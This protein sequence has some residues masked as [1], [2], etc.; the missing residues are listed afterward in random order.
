MCRMCEDPNSTRADLR[1]WTVATIAERGWCL[2]YVEPEDYEESLVYTVGLTG[3]KKPELVVEGLGITDAGDL[4][5]VAS[6]CVSGEVWPGD[7]VLL[8][9]DRYRLV[10]EPDVSELFVALDM[11]GSRVRALRLQPC[12]T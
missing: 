2:Q 12:Q 6:G 4:N 7:T 11:Y 3:L 10:P 8:G 5:K 1:A 9:R